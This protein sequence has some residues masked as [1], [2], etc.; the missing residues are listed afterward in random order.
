[1]ERERKRA[2]GINANGI[3]EDYISVRISEIIENSEDIPDVYKYE[4]WDKSVNDEEFNGLDKQIVER[5][6]PWL[7]DLILV[8]FKNVILFIVLS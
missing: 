3:S 6:L 5:Q 4:Q 7:K 8:L 1:M 2:A